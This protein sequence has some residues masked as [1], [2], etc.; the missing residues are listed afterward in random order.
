MK[1]KEWQGLA[2]KSIV[3]LAVVLL[4]SVFR[5]DDIIKDGSTKALA[6]MPVTVQEKQVAHEEE[7]VPAL[8]KPVLS[9]EA[10]VKK[11]SSTYIRI[12]G[13]VVPTGAAV[14]IRDEYMEQVICLAIDG[15]DRGKPGLD[16]IIRYN[17]GKKYSGKV[18]KRNKND[19]VDS[20]VTE[21]SGGKDKKSRINIKIKTRRLYAPVLYKTGKDYYISLA[22]PDKVYDKIVVVDAGHGGNDEGTSSHN[23]DDEKKYTLLIMRELKD[24]LDKTDIK[25]YYTRLS[26]KKVSKA[27]RTSLANKLKADLF[28]SIHCNS[29]DKGEGTAYG[30]ES[31]YSERKPRNSGLSN[32]KLAKI[33][34]ESVAKEVNNR[35]RGVIRREGLYIMHHSEVPASI[36]EV[37]YMSNKSDLKYIVKKSGQ[38]KIAKG[39]YNGIME[40]LE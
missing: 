29:S 38:K 13:T 19:I 39:I 28:I 16:N 22:I 36:I 12:P 14:Y 26:D 7:A 6:D 27:A 10:H 8:E 11:R 30:V 15:T 35:K 5:L 31:L 25:V 40:A 17:K 24:L 23:G 4:F 3:F 37:G 34:M 9:D 18:M 21:V 32:R 2:V 1:E 20:I 33:L